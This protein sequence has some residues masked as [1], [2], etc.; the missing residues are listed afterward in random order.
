VIVIGDFE[1]MTITNRPSSERLIVMISLDVARIRGFFLEKDS[2]LPL[3]GESY[4]G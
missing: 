2:L 4:A 1:R 3:A